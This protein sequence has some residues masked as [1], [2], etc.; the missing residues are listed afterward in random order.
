MKAQEARK[1]SLSV[2]SNAAEEQLKEVY[3]KIKAACDKG[4]LTYCYF[5]RLLA[6]TNQKL[7]ADGYKVER[8]TDNER[9]MEM[10]YSEISW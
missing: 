6:G 10:E 3:G 5:G 1:A 4:E 2:S 7:I 8:K 9:G